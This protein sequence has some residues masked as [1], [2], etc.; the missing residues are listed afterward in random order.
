VRRRWGGQRLSVCDGNLS[1][2]FSIL[3]LLLRVLLPL[4]PFATCH[5]LFRESLILIAFLLAL[6]IS[7]RSLPSPPS[8]SASSLL[9]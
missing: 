1:C 8:V 4:P 5:F 9:R 6:S 3:P 2:H 7:L